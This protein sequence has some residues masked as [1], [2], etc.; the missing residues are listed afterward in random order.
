MLQME[1][2]LLLLMLLLLWVE[3]LLWIVLGGSIHV[4]VVSIIALTVAT[5]LPSA[6]VSSPWMLVVV[7]TGI[8]SPFVGCL[9]EELISE[10]LLAVIKEVQET[11]SPPEFRAHPLYARRA[12]CPRDVVSNFE[13]IFDGKQVSVLV[14]RI[15]FVDSVNR[16][17]PFFRDLGEDASLCPDRD[18]IGIPIKS[19][20]IVLK[21]TAKQRTDIHLI[22]GHLALSNTFFNHLL[23]F[24]I[25]NRP[26]ILMLG[27]RLRRAF[28]D[29][30]ILEV[31][32]NRGV[33]NV[34]QIMDNH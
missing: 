8:W 26:T 21:E 2:R 13:W 23:I 34:D 15:G 9:L 27:L 17:L 29:F 22:G 14:L 11:I 5:V 4:T 18:N 25:P 16:G 3:S 7:I 24:P 28:R 20:S 12:A 1:L 31:R 30:P 10:L 19:L 6:M 33:D 32:K